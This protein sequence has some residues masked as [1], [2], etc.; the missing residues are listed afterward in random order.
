[1]VAVVS[2][3][4]LYYVS[5]YGEKRC[6]HTNAE[7]GPAIP[8]GTSDPGF[9]DISSVGQPHKGLAILGYFGLPATE[10]T[11]FGR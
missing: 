11:S 6:P 5:Q 9:R 2:I 10:A 7:T 8:K 4:V 1:M 3:P